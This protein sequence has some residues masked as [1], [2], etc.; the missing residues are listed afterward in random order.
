MNKVSV[1]IPTYNCL[2]YLPK[3]IESVLAQD[4]KNIEILIVN[5]NSSDGTIKYLATLSKTHSNVVVINTDG[6]GASSAR[7][8]AIR[9][10][11]GQYVAFL[12]ADDYWYSGKVSEQV[13][14]HQENKHLGMTFT[15]YDHLNENN[16]IIID[17]LAYWN[18]YNSAKSMIHFFDN[19]LNDIFAN[20]II[21]TSTVMINKA[22][23]AK[24][25]L[26]NEEM[27]YCEDWHFWLRVCEHFDI[28]L[29]KH[30]YTGYLMRAGSI[31]QT[32]SK[33]WNNLLSVSEV[34]SHYQDRK[35]S[36]SKKSLSQA[37]ARL[38][39]GY[40][41]YF[42][43]KGDI[44]TALLH[45]FHSLLIDPQTRRVKHTLGD[46]KKCLMPSQKHKQSVPIK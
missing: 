43:T 35:T 45:D 12:D 13:R 36:I 23:F 10:S 19:P 24:V 22:V 11:S 16:E 44:Y 3:A 28:A 9:Q 18:K 5:D 37:R 7:N 25:G 34:I 6:V 4:Y 2:P 38:Q 1:V 46:M 40:A 20:N 32:D 42:R 8:I 17:C 33:R 30:S 39:E 27:S 21:G 41:D 15:N 26:F 29:L 14:V 31:T